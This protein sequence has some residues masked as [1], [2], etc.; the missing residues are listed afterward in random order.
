M[1]S[2]T[3][4]VLSFLFSA[5][6]L[7]KHHVWNNIEYK[8]PLREVRKGV[9][10]GHIIITAGRDDHLLYIPNKLFTKISISHFI[11][12]LNAVLRECTQ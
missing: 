8:V 5:E 1:N 3:R 2:I 9:A 12:V 6:N 4:D 7:S 10:Q 11:K